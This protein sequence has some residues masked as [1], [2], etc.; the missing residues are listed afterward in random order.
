MLQGFPPVSRKDTKTI[1]LGSMPGKDS[2]AAGQYYAHSRNAF[3]PIMAEIYGASP[4]LPYGER[5][6]VL[7]RNGVGLWDVIRNCQRKTS[8]DAHIKESTIVV[9]D[10]VSFIQQHRQLRLIC[11]NG[12]KG[13]QTFRRYV[14]NDLIPPSI[15][16]IRLPS[17]SPANARMNFQQKLEA[18][19]EVLLRSHMG[20]SVYH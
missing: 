10:F 5:L 17:T 4:A 19:R 1:I 20:Y 16:R 6:E 2:L 9:N 12:A 14:D 3:W 11:F 18:W 13:E 15:D 8:L 7:L